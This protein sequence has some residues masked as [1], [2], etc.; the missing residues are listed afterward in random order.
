MREEFPTAWLS[1][2][3][4][5]SD[6]AYTETI[7]SKIYHSA[8]IL[9]ACFERCMPF[10]ASWWWESILNDSEYMNVY[11]HLKQFICTFEKIEVENIMISDVE[12]PHDGDLKLRNKIR[13]RL[14]AL[15]KNPMYFKQELPAITKFLTKK[16]WKKYNHNH[17]LI[18]FESEEGKK[19]YI[20]ETYVPVKV[21]YISSDNR[22]D[23][24]ICTD[25]TRNQKPISFCMSEAQIL[26]E[27]T[28][29][30]CG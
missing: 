1:E 25:I 27:G 23:L 22:C 19:Y 2:F 5:F 17:V 7:E 20:L 29:L 13:Y 26:S 24:L 3:G 15:K 30:F 11:S 18:G 12:L 10:P 14:S 28:Y 9:R 21:K 16:M 8:M 4:C 6:F